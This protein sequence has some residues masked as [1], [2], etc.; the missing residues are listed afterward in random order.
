M[1]PL[2]EA[3][4]QFVEL[5]KKSSKT[6]C[7]VH[8][9]FTMLDKSICDATYEVRHFLT[10]ENLHDY[11]IQPKGTDYRRYVPVVLV[12]QDG[13]QLDTRMSVYRPTT[14]NG[15]PRFNISGAK[16]AFEPDDILMMIHNAGSAVVFNI[17]R[18]DIEA[19][20][21]IDVVGTRIFYGAIAFD[22]IQDELVGRLREISSRGF[23]N[24]YKRG[25]TAIGHL[26]ETELG[27]EANS[28]E[29]PDFMG[30]IEIKAARNRVARGK[31]LFAKVADWSISPLKSSAEI[32]E[33][34]GYERE[35]SKGR[36]ERSLNCSVEFGR[37]NTQGLAFSVDADGQTL[38]EVSDRL[39][40]PT[41]AG[42]K[43]DRL[44]KKLAEKHKRTM[45]VQGASRKIGNQEQ[46]HFVSAEY[47]SEPVVD[48]FIPMIQERMIYMDHLISN[49]KG[50]VVEKGPLFKIRPQS[51]GRLFPGGT[52][53]DL[54][55]DGSKPITS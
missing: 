55:F 1:R 25:S 31:T 39:D 43:V 48:Q 28:A 18:T 22:A 15:D 11:D 9:T 21:D 20:R 34:F 37:F 40:L 41:V 53:V 7:L 42:W 23:L 36:Q 29:A 32:L 26:L 33:H 12:Q 44:T 24:V 54:V 4:A 6:Y 45:W 35:N 47:T 38:N 52:A 14:K 17:S 50:K 2:T 51:F 10:S 46:I 8:M 30:A 13:T 49:D 5:A 27:I 3:E 19:V 16:K